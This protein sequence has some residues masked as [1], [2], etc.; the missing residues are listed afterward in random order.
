MLCYQ[1]G[2]KAAADWIRR[3]T[4]KLALHRAGETQQGGI[5][6]KTHGTQRPT[7]RARVCADGEDDGC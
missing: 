7:I 4:S 2:G 6:S 1:Y 5:S 3:V